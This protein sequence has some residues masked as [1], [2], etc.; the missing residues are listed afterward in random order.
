MLYAVNNLDKARRIFERTTKH[1][2]RV[3]LIIL[4]RMRVLTTM[5]RPLFDPEHLRIAADLRAKAQRWRWFECLGGLLL[6]LIT[7]LGAVW[8]LAVLVFAFAGLILR[9]LPPP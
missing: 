6:L 8:A 4:Q 2:P 7:A 1:R 3:R 9:P 5:K